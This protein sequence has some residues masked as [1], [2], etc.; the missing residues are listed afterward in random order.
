MHGATT[1]VFD[2]REIELA[3][4]LRE[5]GLAWTPAAGQYVY[6]VA[7]TLQESS[8][9]Q[10]RVYFI[11]DFQSFV[12]RLGG[13]EAFKRSLVWLPTWEDARE[14]LRAL[15]VDDEEVELELVRKSAVAR[16]EERLALYEMIA[17]QLS[18]VKLQAIYERSQG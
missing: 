9:F 18:D 10:D 7:G 15:G 1:M 3:G 14:I 13:L 12:D 16:G 6:D 2:D 8:P 4:Q 5:L 11:F 17:Q